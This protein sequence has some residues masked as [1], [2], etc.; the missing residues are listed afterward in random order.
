[1][2]LLYTIT[3]ED[4]EHASKLISILSI[5][6]VTILILLIMNLFK[7]NTLKK[8]VK[9]LENKVIAIKQQ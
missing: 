6:F 2:I 7:V 5:S 9:G 8:K 4:Y 1:M 3:T